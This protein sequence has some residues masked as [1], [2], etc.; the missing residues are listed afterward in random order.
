MPPNS[1]PLNGV[2]SPREYPTPTVTTVVTM[3]RSSRWTTER[4][5]IVNDAGVV[6]KSILKGGIGGLDVL[7][8]L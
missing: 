5:G 6:L 3:K 8:A 1:T 2:E 4:F 7:L